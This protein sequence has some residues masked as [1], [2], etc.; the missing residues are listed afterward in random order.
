MPLVEQDA[1]TRIGVLVCDRPSCSQRQRF[2]VALDG[3]GGKR[4]WCTRCGRVWLC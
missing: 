3:S 2:T 1:P 4:F